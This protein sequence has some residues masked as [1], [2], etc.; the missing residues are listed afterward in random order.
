[1]ASRRGKFAPPSLNYVR[2]RTIT[3]E[4]DSGQVREVRVF[5]QS[6]GVFLEPSDSTAAD[7]AEAPRGRGAPRAPTRTVPNARPAA[8][9]SAPLRRP[10]IAGG[11]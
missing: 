1:V 2:G 8:P 9:R 6:N 3:V 10:D 4:F 5:G 7:T 11:A